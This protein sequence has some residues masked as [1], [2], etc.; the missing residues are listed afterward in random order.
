MAERYDRDLIDLF[1]L[2]DEITHAIAGAI[3]PELLKFER[4]RIAERPQHSE[5]A[6]QFYQH[7]MFHHYRHSKADNLEAQAPLAE[8]KRLNNSLA[9]V[10]GNLHRLFTD[11]AAV[12]HVVGGLRKA[13]FE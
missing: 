5:D 10:E 6:Y 3:E 1:E 13:G 2:Q 8:L 11:E 7:G 12:D 4:D 9:F